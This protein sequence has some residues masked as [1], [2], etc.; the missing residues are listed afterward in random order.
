MTKIKSPSRGARALL[1]ATQAREGGW[2]ALGRESG[3]SPQSLRQWAAG[4]CRPR[5]VARL[6]LSDLLGI[7][8]DAWGDR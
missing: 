5:Y 4:Q 3:L 8:M 1:R 2:A 7:P 6:T